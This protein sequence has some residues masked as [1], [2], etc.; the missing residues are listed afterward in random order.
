MMARNWMQRLQSF[1]LHCPWDFHVCGQVLSWLLPLEEEVA[2]TELGRTRDVTIGDCKEYIS[3]SNDFRIAEL[4]TWLNCIREGLWEN[5]DLK[6]Q[7]FITGDLLKYCACGDQ[8]LLAEDLL[9]NTE[10]SPSLPPSARDMF[11]RVVKEFTP[12]QCSMLLKFATSREKLPTQPQQKAIL[13]VDYEPVVNK[14]PSAA[15]CFSQFHNASHLPILPRK[16]PRYI[17]TVPRNIL[18]SK[19]HFPSCITSFPR[20]NKA[21]SWRF[22]KL[23]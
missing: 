5:L 15:T 7:M 16:A 11:I 9:I 18:M 23:A 6:P 1:S 10:F 19:C 8:Q 2:L 14:C 22:L 21:S 3:L 12:E 20:H 17:D 13:T 4:R